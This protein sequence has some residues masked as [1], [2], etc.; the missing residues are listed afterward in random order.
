MRFLPFY[1]Y[2]TVI[3][4]TLTVVSIFELWAF[5]EKEHLVNLMTNQSTWE[6]N[7][8]SIV[9]CSEVSCGP[10]PGLDPTWQVETIVGQK[11]NRIFY[12]AIML[13]A[14]LLNMLQAAVMIGLKIGF[15]ETLT[16]MCFTYCYIL[17]FMM[18]L[19]VDP[20]IGNA[21][22]ELLVVGIALGAFM[23]IFMEAFLFVGLAWVMQRESRF[24]FLK[25]SLRGRGGLPCSHTHTHT[26]TH[27]HKHTHVSRMVSIAFGCRAH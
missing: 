6:L 24:D 17:A 3:C 5:A 23:I 18:T 14:L 10:P 2:V 13:V 22:Q 25:V 4:E 27:T 20:M 15:R 12:F 11:I 8:T 21:G 1:L 7:K 26:H 9:D 19:K 16:F